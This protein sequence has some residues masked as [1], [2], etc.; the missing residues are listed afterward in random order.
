MDPVGGG[1]TDFEGDRLLCGGENGEVAEKLFVGDGGDSGQLRRFENGT[2]TTLEEDKEVGFLEM[3]EGLLPNE[4]MGDSGAGPQEDGEN[5]EA[6]EQ[7]FMI[8]PRL[9]DGGD[10][11]QLRGSENCTGTIFGEEDKEVGFL[12]MLEGL[13]PN[14]EGMGD[15]GAA[16]GSDRLCGEEYG[17]RF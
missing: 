15:D 5:G 4:G 12:E 8:H 11:G 9:E 3:L 14:E 6:S 1:G 7:Q 17:M 13:L 2:G 10:D 16:N